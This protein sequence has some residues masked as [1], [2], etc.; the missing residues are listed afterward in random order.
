MDEL[1]LE[2]T[3][4][5][6]LTETYPGDKRAPGLVSS[7]L[8]ARNQYY[9]SI[10]RY[11]HPDGAKRVMCSGLGKDMTEARAVATREWLRTNPSGMST[12]T[13]ARLERLVR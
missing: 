11:P 1:D 10:T 9:T 2:H 5:Q 8:D 4:L 6:A 3:L 13:R 7:W 12:T